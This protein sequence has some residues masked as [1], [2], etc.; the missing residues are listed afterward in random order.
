MLKM[1]ILKKFAM[2][3]SKYSVL[4]VLCLMCFVS[5]V[6]AQNKSVFHSITWDEAAA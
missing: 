4:V 3:K 2:E 1:N 6:N 5:L